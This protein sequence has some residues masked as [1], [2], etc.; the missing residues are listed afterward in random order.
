MDMETDR[1]QS[2]ELAHQHLAE[3][4]PITPEGHIAEAQ[5]HALL[6]IAERLHEVAQAIKSLSD[7][8]E[9]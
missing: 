8:A 9:R 1:H 3:A 4:T 2:D 6:A 7:P 5:V